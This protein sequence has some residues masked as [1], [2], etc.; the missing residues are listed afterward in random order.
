MR[1][2]P[3]TWAELILS[4]SLSLSQGAQ[5]SADEK[6]ASALIAKRMDDD[7]GGAATQCRVVM[8]K[9]P[10]HFVKH[11]NGKMVI[12][13]GGKASGFAN[14]K[15]TDSYDIDGISLFHV[16]GTEPADTRAMQV[17]ENRIE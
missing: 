11:F 8:G 14:N 9:E 12:H 7:L 10:S 16:R 1:P 4:L 15:D 6:G 13:S 5:S 2:P 3:S 17:A